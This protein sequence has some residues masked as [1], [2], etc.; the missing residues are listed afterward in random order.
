MLK[1]NE[2]VVCINGSFH[3]ESVK[4]IPNLPVEN[5]IYTIRDVFKQKG[6]DVV[7]LNEI[8]NPHLDLSIDNTSDGGYGFK[9]EP[10]FKANRFVP[11]SDLDLEEVYE[12]SEEN[13]M[14][15]I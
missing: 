12:N 7:L 4:I 14:S 5:E 11:I 10:S 13:L 3:P 9:F 6:E 2:K 1:V 8:S 15:M